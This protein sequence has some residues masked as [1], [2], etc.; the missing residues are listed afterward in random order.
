MAAAVI[1][2]SVLTIITKVHLSPGMLLMPSKTTNGSKI[3]QNIPMYHH[4][5]HHS[6]TDA[7]LRD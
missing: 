6:F 2:R 7:A 1:G 4:I 3:R 5:T